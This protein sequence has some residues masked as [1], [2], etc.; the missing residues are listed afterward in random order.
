MNENISQDLLRNAVHKCPWYNKDLHVV[1]TKKRKSNE[2]RVF[3]EAPSTTE[4]ISQKMEK[5]SAEQQNQKKYLVTF[6]VSG[7]IAQ[8][9]NFQNF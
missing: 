7:D 8:D 3:L 6:C 2:T 4:I 1:I 5:V 9:A